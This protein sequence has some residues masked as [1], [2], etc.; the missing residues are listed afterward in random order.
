VAKLTIR[1]TTASLPDL[2]AD[3]SLTPLSSLGPGEGSLVSDFELGAAPV[4]P[5]EVTGASLLSGRLRG[6]RAEQARVTRSRVTSVEFVD[7]DLTGL[8][9]GG[10]RISQTRFDSCKML[11]AQFDGV[12]MEH[13]VFTG[14]NLDY[15]AL[16][17]IRAIGPVIFAHCTLR[18]A[19]FAGCALSGALFDKCDLTLVAFGPGNYRRCDLRGNDLSTISGTQ[20]L[21]Q[22][23]VAR[24]QL[25]ALA[26]ALAAELEVVV[27]DD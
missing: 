6:V 23:T 26:E 20:Q 2:D 21:K 9:W 1:Q 7:C 5:L 4:S 10:G 12:T 18:E 19:E 22:V 24:P 17:G 25:L 11:G 14:C 27:A 15:A 3:S 8:R 13:V 16:T